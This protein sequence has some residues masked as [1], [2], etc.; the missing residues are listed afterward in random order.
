MRWDI[1][2]IESF[3]VLGLLTVVALGIFNRWDALDAVIIN[4]W[5]IRDFDRAFNLF[6]GNYIPLA[7]P[8]L[9]NGGR[10]PG[11]FF[12][13]LLALPLFFDY[14]YESQFVLNFILN[15]SS[16]VGLFF[17]LKRN[18]DVYFSI[19]AT[20]FLANNL[21]HIGAV[22]FPINPSFITPFTVLFIFLLLEFLLK[23]SEKAFLFIILTLCLTIQIHF[24]IATCFG[25]LIMAAIIL[26]KKIPLKFIFKG[27]IIAVICFSPYL[28]HKQ[29]TFTPSYTGQVAVSMNSDSWTL[30]KIFKAITVQNSIAR[31]THSQRFEGKGRLPQSIQKIH[32]WSLSI[33][34][35]CLVFLV[36]IRSLNK[37][38]S[39]PNPRDKIL[40][41]FF[42]FPSLCYEITN[43][44]FPHYW[45]NHIFVVPQLLVISRFLMVLYELTDKRILKITVT[46]IAVI[47]V[48]SST[49]I[50]RNYTRQFTRHFKTEMVSQFHQGEYLSNG[51]SS[52]KN[53]SFMLNRLMYELKLSP[54]DFY[55]DVYFLG[56]Y[57]LGMR[58]LE[59][60]AGL[61]GEDT[62]LLKRFEQKKRKAC[63]FIQELNILDSNLL[64][65][66][67]IEQKL[68]K[69][70][71][72]LFEKDNN[73]RR[74]E[75]RIIILEKK[76][77][78]KKFL[79]TS[80]MPIKKHS[81]Y[82][83]A[84]NPW[85]TTKSFHDLLHKVKSLKNEDPTQTKFKTL[86]VNEKYDSNGELAFFEAN[87]IILNNFINLPMRLKLNLKKNISSYSLRT[88]LDLAIFYGN[89]LL[90]S[91][92]NLGSMKIWI[93]KKDNSSEIKSGIPDIR[94]LLNRSLKFEIFPKNSLASAYN[95][96][97]G[98]NL[99]NYNQK[100]FREVD[101]PPQTKIEKD[102]F[103]IGFL[104][105]PIIPNK[106]Y[107]PHPNDHLS[108]RLDF[109]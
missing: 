86:S 75:T 66:S 62:K 108:V 50:S 46:S 35:Y 28:I 14:S 16:V 90:T 65:I 99:W 48:I 106:E 6:D 20:A 97:T 76:G 94:N 54:Q 102:N 25:V 52:H 68:K 17:V 79:V 24:Q 77:F 23:N 55:E 9:T 88:D 21:Q 19:L 40:L 96:L 67:P 91:P 95:V 84:F 107:N 92:A 53:S 69:M 87:Y 31:I 32:H 8:D 85:V 74:L 58:R 34:F 71:L 22:Y 12:Y 64:G 51:S 101:L 59:F 4:D 89:N 39:P 60:A 83:N 11:P 26:K 2:K 98:P 27:L 103:R 37:N 38:Y 104:W 78:Q 93:Y 82:S 42:Y 43:P 33:S 70:R 15:V 45:Y 10:L 49:A 3:S 61:Q 36:L 63:Y 29:N 1:K 30:S 109:K 57:P 72:A 81:C 100:W 5:V 47:T 41:S 56:F 13:F 80:Y 44:V 7:G 18:F 73:I 105:G